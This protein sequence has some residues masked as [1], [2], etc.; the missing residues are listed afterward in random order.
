MTNDPVES[1]DG[2]LTEIEERLVRALAARAGQVT[3]QSLRPAAPPAPNWAARGRAPLVLALAA[4]AASV[5][6]LSTAAVS[7]VNGTDKAPVAGTPS[8]VPAPPAL[9]T[10][11]STGPSPSARSGG[12]EDR[13]G[14]S[15][16]PPSTTTPSGA[17]NPGAQDPGGDTAPASRTVTMTL[18]ASGETVPLR[19]GGDVITLRV[20]ISNT[21]GETV[22]DASDVLSIV[23]RGSGTLK[24][25]DI[26]VS[27]LGGDGRWQAVGSTSPSSFGA[28]L[29]GADGTTLKAGEERTYEL[30]VSLGSSF[31]SDITGLRATVFSNAG[32]ETLTAAR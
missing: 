28:E 15:A 17:V 30:R 25:G 7:L 22:E 16:P 23:P 21:V 18:G 11:P 9:T 5:A 24:T 27:L 3:H 26:K 8:D 6:L 19:T 13:D 4:A 29:S 32:E 1:V 12:D 31:P 20:K 10:S 14:T 2:P